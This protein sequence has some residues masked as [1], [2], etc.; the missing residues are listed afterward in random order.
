M[1]NAPQQPKPT[2]KTTVIMVGAIILAG[3]IGLIAEEQKPPRTATG[4][5]PGSGFE[6]AEYIDGPPLTTIPSN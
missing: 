4:A 5:P 3:L 6:T 1:A 2:P